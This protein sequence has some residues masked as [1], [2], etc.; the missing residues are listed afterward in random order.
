MVYCRHCESA[1]A[2]CLLGR[3]TWENCA[4]GVLDS[5]YQHTQV[6]VVDSRVSSV[7]VKSLCKILVFGVDSK[8]AILVAVAR[9]CTDET[10]GP[11]AAR[12]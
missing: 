7:S 1:V 6:C 8:H 10:A 11:E 12:L 9:T 2:V 4:V 5:W 3:R